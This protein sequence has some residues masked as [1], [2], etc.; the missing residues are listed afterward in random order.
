MNTTEGQAAA[1][2]NGAPATCTERAVAALLYLH[3]MRN[4]FVGWDPAQVEQWARAALAAPH[5][6][7]TPSA[8]QRSLR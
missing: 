1:A 4:Q 2:A 6:P 7:F 8:G 3:D 5:T